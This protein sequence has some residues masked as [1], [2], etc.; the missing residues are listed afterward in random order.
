MTKNNV[1]SPDIKQR[2]SCAK[3][4]M[5]ETCLCPTHQIM[6]LLYKCTDILIWYNYS[7]ISLVSRSGKVSDNEGKY[8]TLTSSCSFNVL[9]R[10]RLRGEFNRINERLFITEVRKISKIIEN[11]CRFKRIIGKQNSKWNIYPE[12]QTK[13][14]VIIWSSQMKRQGK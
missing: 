13:L 1:H 6:V 4:K 10:V 11:G 12:S 7:K 14:P 5:K 9:W 3:N 2:A 8:Q